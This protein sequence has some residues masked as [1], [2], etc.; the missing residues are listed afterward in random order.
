MCES[1]KRCK[2]LLNVATAMD[3]DDG[4][5]FTENNVTQYLA[6][7]EEYITALITVTAY[8]RDDQNAATSA[9]PI[10]QLNPKDFTKKELDINPPV[11]MNYM[12]VLIEQAVIDG[13]LPGEQ[14]NF[15]TEA[16]MQQYFQQVVENE[17]KNRMRE[18][19]GLGGTY[20]DVDIQGDKQKSGE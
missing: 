16:R 13:H 9:I 4:I 19:N 3:Y 8:K 6:E 10:N 2:F 5:V 7:L 14:G 11:P 12:D 15:F 1:F 18:A 17:G 20:E